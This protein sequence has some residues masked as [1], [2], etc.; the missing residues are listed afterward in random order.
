MDYFLQ[1]IQLDIEEKQ[2][3]LNHFANFMKHKQYDGSVAG[4]N[5]IGERPHNN[6]YMTCKNNILNNI[7]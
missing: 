6:K 3:L 1:F 4:T 2:M 5:L 7:R